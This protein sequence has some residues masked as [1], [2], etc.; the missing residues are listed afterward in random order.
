MYLNTKTN[1]N[2][3]ASCHKSCLSLTRLCS[4]RTTVAALAVLSKPPFVPDQLRHAYV[5][6]VGLPELYGLH[7]DSHASSHGH[8]ICASR[9]V[10]RQDELS[11]VVSYL[12]I[13]KITY[14][15]PG[16]LLAGQIEKVLV[17]YACAIL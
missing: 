1:Y 8:C 13:N 4:V 15:K 9:Y 14:R 16:Q 3:R 7:Q 12:I 2:H 17:P 5:S 11:G 10:L 6:I